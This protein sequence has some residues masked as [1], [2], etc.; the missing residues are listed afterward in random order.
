M[1][2]GMERGIPPCESTVLRAYTDRQGVFLTR[3]S[4]LIAQR[5]AVRLV[6]SFSTCLER[7]TR[8]VSGRQYERLL[9]AQLGDRHYRDA[10]RVS[11]ELAR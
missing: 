5:A 9:D 10:T 3:F 2:C 8:P 7:I 1:I 11:H 6:D 4:A